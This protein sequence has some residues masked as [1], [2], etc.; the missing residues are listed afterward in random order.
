LTL[1]ELAIKDGIGATTGG[2]KL[3]PSINPTK[4]SS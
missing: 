1:K 2:E 4:L 3:K